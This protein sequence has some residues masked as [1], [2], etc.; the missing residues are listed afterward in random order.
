MHAF[1]RTVFVR[2]GRRDAL[3]HDAELSPPR[4]QA[5][6]SVHAV[7]CEWGTV[8]TANRIR[9]SMMSKQSPQLAVH[10]LR[11][12]I[13][14]ALAA[15]YVPTAVI[16]DGERITVFAITHPKL[17]VEIDG[18]HVVWRRRLQRC[19][20][21]VFPVRARPAAAHAVVARARLCSSNPRTP[22]ARN[23]SRHLYPVLR[24]M[25]YREHNSVMVHWPL[26]KSCAK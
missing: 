24:L 23:R 1:M 22:S 13:G 25:P 2:T 21:R 16:D 9:S 15:E 7:R 11:L 19:G 8:L 10:A 14:K 26:A 6:Q 12:H 5:I 4:V 17:T 18:P 20:A 3:V